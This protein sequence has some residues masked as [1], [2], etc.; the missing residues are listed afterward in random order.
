MFAL[1]CADLDFCFRVDEPAVLTAESTH[2]EKAHYEKWERSNRLSLLLMQSLIPKNIR[3]S[4]LSYSTA[5]GFL[6][7]IE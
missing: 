1:G 7:S 2:E 6:K 3:G 5:I 4:V